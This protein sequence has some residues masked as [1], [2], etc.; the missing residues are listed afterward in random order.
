MNTAA[1]N[2][3]LVA[4]NADDGA[5]FTPCLLSLD[6][7]LDDAYASLDAAYDALTEGW[8]SMESVQRQMDHVRALIRQISQPQPLRCGV[9]A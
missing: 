2:W 5:R 4:Y 6:E 7:Q 8:G 9:A 3:N 1:I